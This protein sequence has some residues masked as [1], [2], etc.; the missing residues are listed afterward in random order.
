M[1]TRF[2]VLL[3][4]LVSATAS[5]QTKQRFASLREAIQSNALTGG[6]A[7]RGVVWI[8]DGRR[9]SFAATNPQTRRQEIRAYDPATGGDTLLFSSEG[10]TI[11]GL[12]T[13]FDYQSFQWARDFKHLVFQTNTRQ[14][15][16]RSGISDFYIYSLASHSLKLAGRNARSAELSPDGT[17]LGAERGGDMYVVDLATQRERRLTSDAT[18]H[19]FNG[20]FD[21]VYEEEF[22][23]AQAWNWSPDSRHIAF[24]RVDERSEPVVQLTNYDGHHPDWDRLR[25]PQPGDSNPTAKIGVLDVTTGKKVWL[26]PG[27]TGDF[28]I[29]RIYWTSRPDTLAMV[30]LNR[31]Q[32]EMRL[33]FFDVTTG[34]KRAVLQERSKTWIDVYDFYANVQDLMSFPEKSHE[35]FWL[36]DRDGFQQIYR[37]DYSGKL[38]NAVTHERSSVTRIEGVDPATQTIF[39]TSTN[40]SPLERQLWQ[41]GFDGAGLRR[42]TTTAGHHS[43]DM[44]PNTSYFIDSWSSVS[45]PRQVDLWATATGRLRTLG[46]NDRTRQ[47]LTTHEYSPVELFSFTTSDGAKLDAS[48]IKPI[49]FDSTK[50]YP[51]VFTIYGGPGSQG[52]YDEFATS[53]WAQWLSQN[54]YLV[55]DVNNRGTNNYGR[56]FMKVVYKQLGKYESM[57]FAEAAKYLRTL[58][59]VDGDHIAIMG[60]SYGGYSTLYSMLMHPDV[61]SL[62]MSNSGVTDWRLYDTIYTERYMSLL[63]DN[64][65]GYEQSSVVVNAPKLRGRLLMI[66]AMMDDNVHPQHTMQAMTAFTNAE[67]DVELRIYPPGRHGSAYNGQSGRLIAE[68]EFDF[69]TRWARAPAAGAKP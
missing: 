50:K 49:P 17:L 20:H 61:F 65:A 47:W 12:T 32:N 45:E 48:M 2:L 57:D 69:L 15:F 68:V 40:P 54:G 39:F 43:I 1:R 58:P 66:H 59:Y 13:A 24:W 29:P 18:E 46:A 5:A 55:I 16:R 53:G 4:L 56:D 30:V 42:I 8:D 63:S 44:S 41:I 60:T 9:F 64:L 38:V 25:I 34:G 10:L 19:V 36:S 52:V 26:D 67:K 35:F 21:W 28:Y 31:Q 62:G 3:S 7:P 14:L 27:I 51:V 33:F 22:G 11:P 37:Y 23:L 6:A